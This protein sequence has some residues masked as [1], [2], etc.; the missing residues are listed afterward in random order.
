MED[1]IPTTE[2]LIAGI[3]ENLRT[4]PDADLDLTNILA[5]HIVKIDTQNSA[6]ADAVMLI[7]NLARER[8]EQKL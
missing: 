2:Q 7:E 5:K 4:D 3:I 8:G 6:A 1:E